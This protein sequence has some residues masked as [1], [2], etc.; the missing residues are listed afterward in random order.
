MRAAHDLSRAVTSVLE[1]I[2]ERDLYQ[3]K[4]LILGQDPYPNLNFPNGLAFSTPKTE[5]KIPASLQNIFKELNSDLKLPIPS[6]GDLSSWAEQG[7]VL[8]N[9]TLTCRSGE[10]NS[11]LGI[12]WRAFTDACVEKLAANGAVAIL[13]G[14]NAKECSRYFATDKLITASHPSPLSAHRGFFGSRP[15]SRANAALMAAG[16]DPIDWSL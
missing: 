8:L 6:S 4:V 12:G 5:S 11:H 7:V 15:F 9:R 14:N 1:R 3:S 10:S 16:K 2:F 13:W